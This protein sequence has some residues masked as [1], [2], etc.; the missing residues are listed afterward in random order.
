MLVLS[1]SVLP[2]WAAATAARTVPL[3]PGESPEDVSRDLWWMEDP[4][5]SM[6]LEQVRRDTKAFRRNTDPILNPGV[7]GSIIWVRLDVV[8][9]G[10]RPGHWVVSLN[11]FLLDSGAIDLVTADASHRLLDDTRASF[12][13]SYHQYGTLAGGFSLP[14]GGTAEIYIRYRG[15]NWSGLQLSVHSE[16]ELQS[17]RRQ[18]ITVFLLLLGGIGTLILYGSVSFVFLG[19]QIFLLYAVAQVAFFAF[20]AHMTGF[21]TIYLFPEQPQLGRVVAPI[22]VTLFVVAMA[23]FAR[24]FF[25]TRI[26]TRSVDRILLGCIVA[27]LIAIACA[28]LDYVLPAFDRRIPLFIAY[29]A[30]IVCWIT[31]PLVAT[32]ATWRWHRDYWPLVVAWGLMSAFTIAMQLVFLGVISVMPLGKQAYGVVVY[33][34]ALFLALAIALRIRAIRA[35]TLQ[36]QRRLGESLAAELA[37]TQ[38]AMRLAEER[39][40]ALQDL[41]EKG[42]LLLAAG[43]DT[44][45]MLSALRNYAAGLRLGVPEDQVSDVGHH[46]DEIA[47]CLNDVLTSAIE[48]SRS[49]GIGDAALALD[50]VTVADLLS[51]L[52]LIHGK[53]AVDKGIR[54]R[55]ARSS[56]RIVTDRVLVMRIV[57]NL[58]SNA[59]D[60][61]VSGGVLVGFRPR[62]DGGRFQ[63]W[64]TGVGIRA[65]DLDTLL[66]ANAGA[67]RLDDRTDGQG[68]GLGIARELA[69]RLGGHIVARSEP[70]RGSVF[71]L[72]LPPDVAAGGGTGAGAPAVLTV[73]ADGGQGEALTDVVHR[74]G[75]DLQVAGSLT[76]AR[77][78][79]ARC[80]PVAVFVD[81]H[82]GGANGGLAVAAALV[83]EF[84]DLPIAMLTYDRSAEV[85]SALA[86]HA[87]LILYKPASR[88]AFEAA[89]R[90]LAAAPNARAIATAD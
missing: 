47:N 12:V 76:A 43:H 56:R 57:G 90:R 60:H 5:G 42:R 72:V 70:G 13:D 36:A 22:A 40:W 87:S 37:E 66:D 27:G 68:A 6:G 84:P 64:D 89:L 77:A 79:I 63:V 54:L 35:E 33:S 15:A 2:A 21:T 10:E 46:I 30:A 32:Y 25:D 38:R 49:G 69:T 67:L 24:V 82:L 17:T 71:E 16:A 9:A 8:N 65:R 59:I 11:R 39:E 1:F 4:G 29:A 73:D 18:Q 83:D 58:V 14:P 7:S 26:R 80:R 78:S 85:R 50:T 52:E 23:Q 74:W 81:H 45:Q 44:R 3:Q 28:P 48:G 75:L 61:T 19:R 34:E 55:I 41:A 51:P 31:L 20:Y 88:A 62:G 53:R 86:R